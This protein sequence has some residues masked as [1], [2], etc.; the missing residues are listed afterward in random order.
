MV[1]LKPV[2]LFFSPLEPLTSWSPGKQ[3][4]AD[5]LRLILANILLNFDIRQCGDPSHPPLW[6]R[7]LSLKE[8]KART[9]TFEK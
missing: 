3:L 9:H 4:A 6:E 5:L 1:C 7:Q 8:R 2:V